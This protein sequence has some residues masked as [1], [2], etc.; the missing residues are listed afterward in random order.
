MVVGHASYARLIIGRLGYFERERCEKLGSSNRPRGEEAVGIK[1]DH[2][3][4]SPLDH[5]MSSA[6][7]F[8][9]ERRSRCARHKLLRRSPYYCHRIT[10]LSEML[11][12][13]LLTLTIVSHADF[14]VS[15]C[16]ETI[17]STR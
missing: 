13:H 1:M 3:P 5:R 17:Y 2:V 10:V 14:T 11:E 15:G 6:P 8:A 7:R 12:C 16:S 4:P 9:F